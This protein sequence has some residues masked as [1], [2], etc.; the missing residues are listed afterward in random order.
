MD[1]S[2]VRLT[3]KRHDCSESEILD[4]TLDSQALELDVTHD[5]KYS[6]NRPSKRSKERVAE[7]CLVV[8]ATASVVGSHLF[9][10]LFPQMSLIII[11]ESAHTLEIESLVALRGAGAGERPLQVVLVGD[12]KQLPAFSYGANILCG[13]KRYKLILQQSLFER[14]LQQKQ[15]PSSMLTLQYRMH[16]EI[17]RFHSHFFYDGAVSDALSREHFRKPFHGHRLGW[18]D[19][20]V[21]IDTRRCVE[22]KEI[23]LSR[24]KLLKNTEL[25]ITRQILYELIESF[26]QDVW[27]IEIGIITPYRA[28][29]EEIKDSISNDRTL[30]DLQCTVA[31][32]DSFQ[33]SEMD[34]V[35]FSCVRSN[36]HGNIG[37]LN[38]FRR[39]NVSIS[40]AK[41][42]LIVI[43]DSETLYQSRGNIWKKF[44][45][46]CEN[47]GRY[48]EAGRDGQLSRNIRTIP[49]IGRRGNF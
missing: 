27:N 14:L 38:N 41:Y 45:D 1:P 11:D 30:R 46:Y 39:C 25:R 44:I 2:I 23:N 22:K 19:P 31:T 5:P 12:E 16:P 18:F 8:L 28:Q 40:R 35:I 42:S 6:K 48:L 37:F 15:V 21:F 24:G 34:I 9:S 32:I 26:K 4:F 10:S 49:R 7:R 29:C 3:S 43:G 17:S 20:M 33:G 36:E 47:S 13:N